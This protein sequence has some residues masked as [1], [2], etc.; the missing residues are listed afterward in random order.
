[1]NRLPLRRLLASRHRPM[2]L[3]GAIGTMLMHR[4]DDADCERLNLTDPAA[5]SEV[6]RLYLTAGAEI[7]TTNT[8][9]ASAA[10]PSADIAD[11]LRAA[12][13]IA[14]DE[15]RRFTALT[16]DRPRYVAASVGPG[17]MSVTPA[18]QLDYYLTNIREV[19]AAGA[20]M[21]LV[22][23][24]YHSASLRSCIEAV[25]SIA[26]CTGGRPEVAVS[27]TVSRDGRL[28]S[29]EVPEEL[30]PLL[31][32]VMP[33]AVG[34]NCCAGP[35]SMAQCARR[36]A[37]AT[38]LPLIIYPSAGLPDSEGGYAMTPADFAR[39]VSGMLP[40]GRV[41]VIGGCCGTTPAHIASLAETVG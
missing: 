25:D 8:F 27:F 21:L 10:V 40:A 1:M 36:L 38:D 14:A 11:R 19:M 35:A 12:C 9:C 24:V 28:M 18:E 6:H 22:E 15:A 16:P 30:L 31:D 41:A 2:I 37:E 17:D 39:R 13:R 33:L 26:R 23:S 3:D 20:D 4:C 34:F 29:G 7:I 5:V 32:A